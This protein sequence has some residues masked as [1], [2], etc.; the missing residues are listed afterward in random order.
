MPYMDRVLQLID[1]GKTRDEVA[2]SVGRAVRTIQDRLYKLG[3][4]R[5]G[6]YWYKKGEAMPSM[7]TTQSVEKQFT[8]DEVATLK[9][10]AS[11]PKSEALLSEW[12]LTLRKIDD[13][14]RQVNYKIPATLDI[15]LTKF[16]DDMS[17]Q[18]TEVVTL[19]L[20]EFIEKY[21]RLSEDV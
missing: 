8:S 2:E 12:L 19:A 9:L 3:Y 11:R 15:R 20:L 5:S 18:K 16:S 4:G 21:E 1:E 17:L 7:P 10:L 13:S 14:K 6:D